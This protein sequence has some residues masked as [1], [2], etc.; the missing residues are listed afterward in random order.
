MLMY[1]QCQL[2]VNEYLKGLSHCSQDNQTGTESK[3][4]KNP[5]NTWNDTPI[6]YKIAAFYTKYA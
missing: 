4:T 1:K 6:F 2:T 5:P 3:L